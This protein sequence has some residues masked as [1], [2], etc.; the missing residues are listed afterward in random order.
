MVTM[1]LW[2]T[3]PGICGEIPTLTA[4]IP[5]NKKSDTAVV[6]L[7]GG[8]YIG[9][10]EHEGKGY[11]DFFNNN[12]ITAFVVNYRVSPH[13]FPLPL[14]DSR[15]AIQWV[16]YFADR[17]GI[18][19]NKV[20]I[21]GSSAGG[22]LAA[23][24]STY[25][26]KINDYEIND[27]ISRES[28]IPDGHILCYPVINLTGKPGDVHFGSGVSLLGEKYAE[29]SYLLTPANK[30]NLSKNSACIFMAYL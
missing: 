3:V 15:R 5:E 16:R 11:A 20:L 21:M 4:Y 18:D 26:E 10:S 23:L 22:H 13:R 12:G 14:L 30:Y 9:R 28:F 2:E 24:T 17:Y 8:G 1:N 29:L 7:P 27:E 19:K 6:I 25:F